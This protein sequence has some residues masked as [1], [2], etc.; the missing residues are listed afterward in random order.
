M[1]KTSKEKLLA[2][3]ENLMSYGKKEATIDPSLLKYLDH[4]ALI[5]IRD[6]LKA[7]TNRLSQDDINWLQ[8]FK[9]E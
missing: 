6:K 5:D 8:K 4:N 9:K 2:E 3:I 1:S 7:R